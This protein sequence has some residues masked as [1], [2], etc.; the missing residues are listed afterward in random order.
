M[1]SLLARKQILKAKAK[2][3]QKPLAKKDHAPSEDEEISESSGSEDHSNS[4]FEGHS[5]YRKGGYHPVQVGDLYNGRYTIEKKLGWGHFSTVWLASDSQVPDDHPHKLVAVKVQ[6]SAPQYTDA[7]KDEI[8]LLRACQKQ[9]PHLSYPSGAASTPKHYHASSD[10]EEYGGQ[11]V[12]ALLNHFEITGPHGRHVCLV[13]ETMGPNLLHG[14][15]ACDYRGL[16]LDHV[17]MMTAQILMGLAFLH[18]R[19]AII[20]TDLKPENFL[21]VPREP[22]ALAAVQRERKAEVNKRRAKEEEEKRK[23]EEKVL[24]GEVKLTKNQKKKLKQKAKKQAAKMAA[25]QEEGEG[26]GEEDGEGEKEEAKEKAQD[27]QGE[28]EES[29]EQNKDK[30]KEA[31]GS[32]TDDK[33]PAPE[34]SDSADLPSPSPSCKPSSP[35]SLP[36]LPPV[37]LPTPFAHLTDLITRAQQNGLFTKIA[38]LGNAC[39]THRHFTDDVTT[40][41]YRSPEVLVGLPYSTPIDIW[42]VACLVFELVTGDFLF[43]P[44]ESKSGRHTRDEDHLAL[45]M[46]LLGKMPKKVTTQGK[47]SKDY[48]NKNGQ[49][50]NIRELEDWGLESVLYEKYHLSAE[51]ARSLTSFLLP[52]LDL[53]A[54]TRITA[55]EALRHEWLTRRTDAQHNGRRKSHANRAKNN[56]HN[57]HAQHSAEELEESDDQEEEEEASVYGEGDESPYEGEDLDEYDDGEEGDGADDEEEEEDGEGAD[58][59]YEEGDYQ[60]EEGDEEEAN[61]DQDDL[62]LE[63]ME[64][65]TL[66]EQQRTHQHQ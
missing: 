26:E 60:I 22:Y 51:E 7:A 32:S 5:G 66:E 17:R 59:E 21:L 14:I 65:L 64:D 53:N 54:A 4:D 50:R 13:F 39:W 43:D 46:E 12:V 9:G 24:S 19:C 56:K 3:N 49:L 10:K 20:H 15:K 44:K 45:M 2:K 61:L 28:K 48:F 42:S 18:E 31:N 16:P 47:L 23:E 25:K 1:N 35:D 55:R 41:Q 40:R 63:D 11:F 27:K 8:E 33:Q 36:I 30:A 6:K 57:K 38:D 62:L 58:D 29:K 52:M 37:V 34:S